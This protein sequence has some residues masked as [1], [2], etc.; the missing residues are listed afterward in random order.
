MKAKNLSLFAIIFFISSMMWA[1]DTAS[2]SA[3]KG[4][5]LVVVIMVK[6]EEAVIKQTLEMYCQADPHGD[7]ISYYVYDTGDDAWSPTM[8]KA[9]ELFDDYHLSNYFIMQE[10]FVDF[11]TSRNRALRYAEAKFPHAYFMIMPDAEWYLHDVPALLDFCEKHKDD[12]NFSAYLMRILS[13]GLDFYTPRLIR[14][15]KVTI[16]KG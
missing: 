7:R 2:A 5:L 9:K 12:T 3:N 10:P 6:N 1:R 8:Q 15:M 16:L 13:P 14:A 11:S 4:P